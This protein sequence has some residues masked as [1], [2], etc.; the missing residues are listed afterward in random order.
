MR[1]SFGPMEDITAANSTSAHPAERM[2]W[3][4]T[5]IRAPSETGAMVA[6]SC[7]TAVKNAKDSQSVIPVPAPANE[8]GPRRSSVPKKPAKDEDDRQVADCEPA[9]RHPH[10]AQVVGEITVHPQPRLEPGDGG[11]PQKKRGRREHHQGDGREHEVHQDDGTLRDPTDAGLGRR[12]E[13][14]CDKQCKRD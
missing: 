5:S 8:P 12:Q 1:S 4:P 3:A 14:H 6:K 10:H 2:R 7:P 9:D 11:V 13:S